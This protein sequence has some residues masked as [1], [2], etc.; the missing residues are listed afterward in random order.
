MNEKIFNNSLRRIVLVVDSSILLTECDHYW[1][2]SA[3]IV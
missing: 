3:E 2:K 1:I